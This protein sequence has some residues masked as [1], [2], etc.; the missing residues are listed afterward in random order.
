MSIDHDLEAVYADPFATVPVVFGAQETRGFFDQEDGSRNAEP[1]QGQSRGGRTTSVTIRTASLTGVAN[2]KDIQV[3]G[4][5]YHIVDVVALGDGKE[6]AL[7]LQR[8]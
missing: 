6:T 4:R 1:Y 8:V 5:T 3:D 7:F 2:E